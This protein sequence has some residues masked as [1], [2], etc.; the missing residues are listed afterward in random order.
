MVSSMSPCIIASAHLFRP[1][2]STVP[3]LSSSVGRWE[4][5]WISTSK[6]S[7]L[8]YSSSPFSSWATSFATASRTGLRELCLLYVVPV[9]FVCLQWLTIIGRIRHHCHCLL[10]LPK[11]RRG[12]LEW[13]RGLGAH[14]CHDECRHTSSTAAAFEREVG[15]VTAQRIVTSIGYLMQSPECV[16]TSRLTHILTSNAA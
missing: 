4:N 8:P 3:W 12:Y 9:K 7:W 2:S 14:Q 1:P 13:L 16:P 10:V 15:A 11:P 5:P 6:F